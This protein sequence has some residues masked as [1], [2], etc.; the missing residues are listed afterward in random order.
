M[1]RIPSPPSIPALPHAESNTLGIAGFVCSL[2]GIVFTG[3]LLC[4]I[5]LI[6]SLIA[7]G[8]R[9]RGFAIAGLILGLFG[10]CGWVLVFVVA[11]AAILAA[12]GL[13]IVAVAL[14]ET[15][16]VEITGD[17]ANMAIAIK[18]YEQDND[19]LPATLDDL[20]LKPSTLIDPWGRRYDYHF[21][22]TAPGFDI[23]SRGE[24]GT[25]NTPDDVH[26]TALGEAWDPGGLS[27]EVD[28]DS[29]TGRVTI[30]LGDRTLVAE[31]ADDSGRVSID[32]GDRIVEIVGDEKGGRIRVDG[33]EAPSE[34]DAPAAP[35][36]P[37]E[38]PPESD[39]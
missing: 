5:G 25:V 22:E 2:V 24:D 9:P 17:M 15:E 37:A 31:G 23:V 11:G 35:A 39:N 38:A 27:V 6:L 36:A 30:R 33:D 8:R 1:T 10:T 26:F 4:P 34:A 3:G 21:M 16:K 14:T 32:L 28:E 20:D 19:V 12:L 7:I 13:T 29:D 18:S